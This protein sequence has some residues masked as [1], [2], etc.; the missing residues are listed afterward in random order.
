MTTVA[1]PRRPDH[2]SMGKAI[3][4]RANFF[5]IL[6]IPGMNLH[7]YEVSILPEANTRIN[8][9]LF[10]WEELNRAGILHNAFPVFDGRRNLFTPRALP[11]VDGTAT[12]SV[13]LPDD[14][15]DGPPGKHGLKLSQNFASPP[16]TKPRPARK[17]QITLKKLSDINMTRLQSFLNGELQET[18]IECLLALDV[19]VRHGP[20]ITY[21][22]VGR[23]FF[24]PEGKQF[25][26][27]GAELWQGFH[28]SI[29]PSRGRLWLNLDV[30]ATAFYQPGPVVDMVAKIL[31]RNSADDIRQAM[32]DKDRG[33]IEKVL[34]NVKVMTTHRG[35]ARR[36]WRVSRIT[37]TSASKTVFPMRDE[38]RQM[39]VAEYFQ[40]RY[41]IPLHYA[42]FPCLVVGDPNKH[43]YLP[44]EV[45][46]IIPG[47]RISRKLN[48]KQT[49]DM[50][51]FTCQSP[52][53]RSNKIAAGFNL[54][55]T[56]AN[57]TLAA[58]ETT[59]GREMGT[60]NARVLS[61]PIVSYH[62]NSREPNITPREGQWNLKD[63][64]VAQ[65]TPISS[66][67]VIIFTSERECPREDVQ[68]FIRELV[69]TCRDT[70]ISVATPQPPL[71]YSNPD[72]NI[73]LIMKN[74]FMD[75]GSATA[76][77]PQIILCILPN[78]GVPLY[79]EI[80]RVSD[81]IIGVATQCLL[82]KHILNV[83]KQYCANVCLK[84]NVKMGGTNAYLGPQQ[85][86]F[87]SER[88]TIVFGADVTHS[89]P[90]EGMKPSIAALV[91]SMDAQCSKYAGSIRVHRG[92]Q[93][94][95]SELSNMVAELLR[96]FYQFCG[97]KPQRIVFYRDGV[98]EGAFAELLRSEVESIFRACESL[99]PGYRPTLSFIVVQKR[100]HARFFPIRQEDADEKSGNVAPGTIVDRDIT[101]PVEFDFFLASHPG[102]Q[103][104]SKPTH[105]HVIYD[106]NN[107][108]ADGLQELTYRLCYLYCRATRAVSVCPPA[109]Y[110]HLLAARARFHFDEN[111][112]SEGNDRVVSAAEYSFR[113]VKPDLARLMYFL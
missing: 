102:L 74:G 94:I 43:I 63:K 39:S 93:E 100:H 48:E 32:S 58:F 91:G 77:R 17:F 47:Q 2:G 41:H 44:M 37:P 110:A 54:I 50:I 98:P 85:L 36:R 89:S 66:W 53:I 73:E 28:Q 25:I 104:T 71:R 79:A 40:E 105:Y 81:T 5:P 31:G 24:T 3:M 67:A 55:Q 21:T 109:Y 87:V 113:T 96:T 60:V 49:A 70:G 72:G 10:I 62:P 29:R 51:R 56:E 84:M 90:G 45:C 9:R 16:P 61:T 64:K 112:S 4:L 108:S 35:N 75:A 83:K 12:F 95:M 97:S 65:S 52:H 42:H 18:P 27:N 80:K 19:I 33:K 78:M 23:S 59:F 20:S 57:A 88:P 30:S 82:A 22:T 86:P 13:D 76:G 107:F 6:S 69:S 1:L 26:A 7:H 34:K 46:Q 92:R 106:E 101:H 11:L 103:G 68:K 8:R 38:G 99:E 111:G 14:D 15:D